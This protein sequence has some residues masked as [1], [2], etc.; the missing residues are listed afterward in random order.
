M[1]REDL[2]DLSI[3]TLYERLRPVTATKGTTF[4]NWGQSFECTPLTVFEPTNEDECRL[5]FELARREGKHVSFAGIGHSPSDL[6]CT[7]EFMLRT[8]KLNRVLE[9]NKDKKYAIVQGGI[10]LE[11]LHE[12]LA[13]YDLSMK[14]LGSISAQTLAGVITTATHGTGIHYGV[15][16]TYVMSLTLLLADGSRLFC[17]REERPDVFMASLCGLG[18]TGLL[19]EIQIEVSDVFR[20]KDVQETVPFS[21]VIDHLDE[22]VQSCDFPRFW[23]YPDADVFRKSLVNRTTEPIQTSSSWF[24]SSL[25]GRYFL[26]FALYLGRFFPSLLPHIGRFAAWLAGPKSTTVDLSKNIF[27]FDCLF[28][29]YT[30]EWAI[31]YTETKACL[32]DL[33]AWLSKERAD[34]KGVRPH[35][36]IE[37][38]FSDA[39]DIWLSPS[40]GRKSTWLGIVQYKPYGSTVVYKPIFDEFENIIMKY[41]GRPH[42]AK[43]HPF[44]PE[45]LRK[46]Y[47]HFDDFVKVLQEV[48]PDGLLRNEYVRRHIFGDRSVSRMVFERP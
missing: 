44:Y 43:S 17:S 40:F 36:P 31:P 6:A 13:V 19:L 12:A 20:L 4:I 11:D 37:V 32:Q 41:D 22:Y 26:E 28:V 35:F 33:H 10:I 18:S 3:E 39:D 24:W 25:V 29:Q 9:I 14:N 23:W 46:H 8:T 2:S 34:P 47:P 16:S 7:S 38:R 5:V 48:D 21:D 42:W 45:D 15:I 27:N 30:T 1:S